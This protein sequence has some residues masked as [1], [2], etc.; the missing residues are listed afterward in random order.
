MVPAIKHRGRR[1][2]RH[3][4]HVSF[5]AIQP[6]RIKGGSVVIGE[7]LKLYREEASLGVRAFGREIGLSAATISRIERGEEMSA[8]SQLLLM[9]WLF[10]S[11]DKKNEGGL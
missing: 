9:N 3:Q 5:K 4:Y 7:L 2:C 8:H 10:K 11:R 6:T 1:W